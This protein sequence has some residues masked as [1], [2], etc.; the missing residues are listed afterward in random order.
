LAS[1]IEWAPSFPHKIVVVDN[2]STDGTTDIVEEFHPIVELMRSTNYGFG[3]ANN[4]AMRSHPSQFY[5]LHNTD[6]Y[7]QADSLSPA[8]KFMLENEQ[9]GVTGLPL[10]YPDGSSQT[11]A[12]SFSS[13]FKWILQA[14]GI[15]KLVHRILKSK[16]GNALGPIFARFRVG[17]TYVATHDGNQHR[18]KGDVISA[19]WVSAASM[20]M[21]HEA[22][23]RTGGFDERIFLYGEDQDLGFRIGRQGL[24]VV[25]LIEEPVIHDHGWGKESKRSAYSPLKYDSLRYFV[26]K[27]F[28]HQFFSWIVMR[29]LIPVRVYGWLGLARA[30]QHRKRSRMKMKG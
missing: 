2:G 13:P 21:S 24:A 14:F 4:L 26:D 30:Q 3:A 15:D 6:A 5:Y 18:R 16:V 7:L 10:V 8:I 11:S 9:V 25:Q 17:R 20:L 1:L 19:D 27:H 28:S 22:L 12:Y 29:A 23:Q